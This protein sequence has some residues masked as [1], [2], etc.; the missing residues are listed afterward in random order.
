[1]TYY[2]LYQSILRCH[3]YKSEGLML[4]KHVIHSS[5]Q[6]PLNAYLVQSTGMLMKEGEKRGKEHKGWGWTGQ[7]IRSARVGA[8]RLALV[9]IHRGLHLPNL[10]PIWKNLE[11]TDFEGILSN[12]RFKTKTHRL[13]LILASR[14]DH[15]S[16]VHLYVCTRYARMY[17]HVFLFL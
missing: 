4:R 6:C 16:Q 17:I 3:C 8:Y 15:F 1:M 9:F 5:S 12:W 11:M 14:L 10:L 2:L 7:V 13:I